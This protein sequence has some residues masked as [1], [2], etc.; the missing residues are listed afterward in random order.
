MREF[1]V[2]LAFK[3]ELTE[4]IN[5]HSLEQPSNTPDI[6]LAEYLCACLHAYDMTMQH[7]TQ[8][9]RGGGDEAPVTFVEQES[10]PDVLPSH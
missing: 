3:R 9:Y 6:I 5:K 7:R 1:S 2:T 4:L 10:S 8:W